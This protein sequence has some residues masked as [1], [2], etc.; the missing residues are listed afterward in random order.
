MLQINPLLPFFDIF[1]VTHVRPGVQ[2]ATPLALSL[3]EYA[4]CTEFSLNLR[5]LRQVNSSALPRWG[6]I[7]HRDSRD[8]PQPGSF[9]WS[10]REDPGNEVGLPLHDLPRFCLGFIV[11]RRSPEW[12]TGGREHAPPPGNFLMQSGAF[13]DTNLSYSVL[14]QG[15]L[16]SCA[17]PSLRL[18]DFSNIVT[19]TL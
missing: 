19:Y 4:F 2:V 14:R 12:P 13:W 7:C 16:N 18:D 17:L 1:S 10:K 8:Q 15:I 3:S 11:W 6:V 5:S 9:L